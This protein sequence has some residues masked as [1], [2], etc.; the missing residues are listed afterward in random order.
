MECVLQGRACV[1]GMQWPSGV[2]LPCCVSG[3]IRAIIALI[4]YRFQRTQGRC[5]S[6]RRDK[7]EANK[8]ME[9]GANTGAWYKGTQSWPA[10]LGPGI[11]VTSGLSMECNN[12]M[13]ENQICSSN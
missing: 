13:L 1:Q 11:D 9:G 7:L 8:E 2:R 5:K 10:G 6:V 12:C 4:G 3:T